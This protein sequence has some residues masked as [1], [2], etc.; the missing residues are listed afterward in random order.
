[1]DYGAHA[2]ISKNLCFQMLQFVQEG[3]LLLT[4]FMHSDLKIWVSD[5]PSGRNGR[6]GVQAKASRQLWGWKIHC[7]AFQA[8]Q[9]PPPPAEKLSWAQQPV[10]FWNNVPSASLLQDSGASPPSAWLGSLGSLR[11]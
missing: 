9:R 1:M 4:V 2:S 7:P 3:A 10:V 5:L 6:V 8:F 11:G